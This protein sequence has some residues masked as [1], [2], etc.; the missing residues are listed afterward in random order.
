MLGLLVRKGSFGNTCCVGEHQESVESFLPLW[1]YWCVPGRSFSVVVSL[2]VG[3]MCHCLSSYMEVTEGLVAKLEAFQA[4]LVKRM[5][6][7]GGW[8]F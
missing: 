4:V 5:V 1:K 7:K 2:C 8:V 6:L 3:D